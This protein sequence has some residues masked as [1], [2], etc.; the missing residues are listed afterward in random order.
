[1]MRRGRSVAEPAATGVIAD[2]G[3][4][5]IAGTFN[6]LLSLGVYQAALFVMRPALAYACAWIAGIAF[7][8]AFY[9]N[10]VFPGGKQEVKDRMYL[11]VSYICVFLIGVLVL[12]ALVGL[13][14]APRLAIL[15]TLVLTTLLNFSFSRLILRRLG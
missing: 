2:A 12:Q 9:P 8:M 11:A 5:L 14:G 10:K 4:F 15:G 13:S 3:R 7:L 1:M 6:V